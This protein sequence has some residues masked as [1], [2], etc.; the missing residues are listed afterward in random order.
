VWDHLWSYASLSALLLTFTL[1]VAACTGSVKPVPTQESQEASP[2]PIPATTE[3]PKPAEP[4]PSEPPASPSTAPSLPVPPLGAAPPSE[5][6]KTEE[7]PVL[8]TQPV[9]VTAQ[10]ESYTVQHSATATR[11]E[12]SIMETPVNIQVVPQQV[13]KDQQAI[14]LERATQNVSGVYLS[15]QTQGQPVDEFVIRGFPSNFTTYRDWFPLGQAGGFTGKRDVANL[16]RIEILKGPASILFGRIEPGGIVNLVTKRPMP[17]W[18]G[19]LQQQFGSFRFYRTHA[20]VTGPVTADGALLVRLNMAY[21]TAGSFREF[22]TNERVFLAP[23]LQWNLS[24]K[25]KATVELDYLK[26][27]DVPDYGLPVLGTRPAPVSIRRNFGEATDFMRS[28]Q[29]VVVQSLTHQLAPNWTVIQRFTANLSDEEDQS[30]F[31]DIGLDPDGRTLNRFQAPQ[32]IHQRD[33]WG[34]LQLAGRFDTWRLRHRVLVG[35]DGYTSRSKDFINDNATVFDPAFAVPTIDLFN[36]VHGGFTLLAPSTAT[37]LFKTTQQWFGLFAQDQ[38]ELPYRLHLLAGFR[39]DN[40]EQ[41]QTV[42]PDASFGSNGSSH[43]TRV[44]P[45]VGVL[46]RPQPALALYGNYVE[47]FGL[48]NLGRTRNDTPLNPEIAKQWE[49]GVK[50]ELW[51]GRFLATLAY[52]NVTKRNISAP[53]PDP[54]FAALGFGVNVGESRS[55]GLELD[56]AGEILPGLKLIGTY[57]YTDA[58]VTKDQD[59]DGFGNPGNQGNRLPGVPRHGGSIWTTYTVQDGVLRHVTLGG[60]MVARSERQGDFANS[61]QLPGYVTMDLMA[62]YR[63]QVGRTWFTL[64]LNANNVL[65]KE[66]YAGSAFFR[67]RVNPGVPQSFVGLLRAEIW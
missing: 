53:D 52:F 27:D 45:R 46:W 29:Y 42:T 21:E 19:M 17:L 36:P 48:P 60:G 26:R 39:Y 9:L 2:S 54:L 41:R 47:N 37:E 61:Y 66:Y 32:R 22:I 23:V 40:A 4:G 14:R 55:R 1:V 13:L 20:D 24:E 34:T 8:E 51:D 35:G 44:S 30:T 58:T 64:Q 31:L 5:S 6:D 62:A 56:M 33:L 67:S 38:I 57:A 49:L 18:Y 65:D 59:A 15:N 16:E 3:A 43:D 12:T 28:N 11:T 50:T 7:T 63:W 25:T 10:R